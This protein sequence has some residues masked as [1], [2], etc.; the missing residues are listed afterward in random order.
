MVELKMQFPESFFEEE[1]RSGY[2]VSS[3]MKKIWA[4]ELDLLNE[5]MR[6]CRKY[7]IKYYVDA[8]TLLGTIRHG[9][10][11]P[12]D[13]DIDIVMSRSE[14]QRFC[15]IAEKE[16]KDP[17]FFQTDETDHGSTRGH[18]QLR[19][20][21]TTG[22]IKTELDYKYPFNQG[23]FIDIFPND[24]VPANRKKR[25]EL[26]LQID[27]YFSKSKRYCF[28]YYEINTSKGIKKP[29]KWLYL[30][31]FRLFNKGYHNKYFEKLESVKCSYNQEESDRV[32]NL[33][34]GSKHIERYMIKKKW[35]EKTELKPFEML[36][37]P[38]PTGY[39]YI[40]KHL[41]GDW[42]KY[43]VGT[44][45]HGGVIFD[46]DKSYIEYFKGLDK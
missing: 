39:K 38:V 30:K 35:I 1:E 5:A 13:D 46:T 34:L 23:I 2:T 29:I 26:G 31:L 42:E 7:D 44:T 21:N 25:E 40:L 18:A 22:I 37:V 14:Y 20:S 32:S 45:I 15:E 11:V 12:W 8:G 24:N 28:Y 4:V 17:Y 9:G 10:F 43:V 19:N 6:V 3:E 27:K 36:Q 41:Y 16:F 33:C